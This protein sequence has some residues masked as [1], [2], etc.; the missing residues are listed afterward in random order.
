MLGQSLLFGI[1]G[2][3]R[4]RFHCFPPCC[5]LRSAA[6]PA[7][8][9][10]VGGS[11]NATTVVL[12][13]TEL[14]GQWVGGGLGLAW[15]LLRCTPQALFLPFSCGEAGYLRDRPAPPWPHLA[16][17]MPAF[18]ASCLHAHMQAFGPSPCPAHDLTAS[19][20]PCAHA[21][22]YTISTMLLLRRNLPPKYR[23]LITVR[24]GPLQCA[25]LVES[26]VVSSRLVSSSLTASA[27]RN[28]LQCTGIPSPGHARLPSGC[29]CFPTDTFR[30]AWS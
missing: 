23:L 19:M 10:A 5:N 14:L 20:P 27:T 3:A 30:L 2:A 13:L 18:M 11:S 9:S 24:A 8:C 22:F 25:S 28:H 4:W 17:T 1:R 6:A 21:G 29:L 26:C 12:V 7:L 16:S 15:A